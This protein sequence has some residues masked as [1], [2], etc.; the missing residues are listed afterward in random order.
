MRLR[1]NALYIFISFAKMH[2]FAGLRQPALMRTNASPLTFPYIVKFV[3]NFVDTNII[4]YSTES[5][6]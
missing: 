6:I 5:D 2:R 1:P 3:S 4:D